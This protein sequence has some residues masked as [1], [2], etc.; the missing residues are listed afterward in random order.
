MRHSM[1]QM[2]R[3]TDGHNGDHQQ[4]GGRA[5]GGVLIC[6]NALSRDDT[7]SEEILIDF[8]VAI[9]IERLQLAPE[10]IAH[11]EDRRLPAGRRQSGRQGVSWCDREMGA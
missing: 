7:P 2:N 10:A 9:G 11:Q 5:G 3:V 8:A 6:R 4:E 1:A